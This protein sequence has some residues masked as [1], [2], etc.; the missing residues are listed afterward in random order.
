MFAYSIEYLLDIIDVA[1]TVN[2]Q[3][4]VVDFFLLVHIE[5]WWLECN[6]FILDL[7]YNVGFYEYEHILIC[8]FL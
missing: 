3:G 1:S 2:I 5:D 8:V 4:I 7:S 6:Y